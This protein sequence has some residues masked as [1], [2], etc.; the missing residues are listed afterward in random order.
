VEELTLFC[1]AK[2]NLF[3]AITGR[4]SD[5]FHDLVSLV[6]PLDWGDTLRVTRAA[7]GEFTVLCDDPTVPTD[8]SNLVLKAARAFVSRTRWKGGACFQLDKVVPVGAGLGGGSS[9]AVGA[10][11]AVNE[12]AGQPLDREGLSKVAAEVGSDCSLFLSDRAVV[13]RGRGEKIEAVVGAQRKRLAAERILLIKPAFG[14]NTGWAYGAL[15]AKAP[16][17]YLP[18]HE[19]ESRLAAWWGDTESDLDQFAF[20]SMEAAVWA[21]NLALPALAKRLR[22]TC[23]VA[24][25]MSGSGSACFVILKVGSDF[26]AI[27][28][29]VRDCWGETALV[30]PVAL[31]A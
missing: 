25:H 13:M 22:D 26:S 24:L 19:A 28:S 14:V 9:D 6:S 1:P 12:L 21:K 5:G 18:K 15:A 29:V 4:R 23:G 27:E 2:I 17:G 11:K 20:N 3:L 30:Q 10:L 7:D 31:K 16:V 8:E